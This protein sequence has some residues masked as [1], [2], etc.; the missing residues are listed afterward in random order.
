MKKNKGFNL[1][2]KAKKNILGGTMMLSKKPELWLPKF[3]PTYFKKANKISVW[4]L[5][6]K[7]YIDMICAVGQNT[8]GYSNKRIDD[9]V[10]RSIKNNNMTTLNCP[11]EVE[12]SEILL[13]MNP[14]AD[15][16]KFARTGGEANSI[17]IRIA[18]AASKK[19][20]I[21]IC[22]Y[23]GWHDWYLAVNLTKKDGLKKHLLGGLK[24]TGVPK[25]LKNT[26]YPFEYGRI[27]QLKEIIKKKNIGIIKI[28]VARSALPDKKFIKGVSQLA[29]RNKI[30]LIFDECTSGFRRNFGGLYL[31]TGVKPDIVI[32]GKAIGN[33]YA[34]TAVVGNKK[35]MTAASSCFI[36][37][38]F[39]TE[40][41]GYVAAINTLKEMQRI[42]SWKILIK[43][44]K[45][46]INGLKK[47]GKKYNLN[48]KVEGIESIINFNFLSKYNIYYKTYITQEMLKKGYLASNITYVTIHHNKA[49]VDRY[50]KQMELIFKKIEN[51]ERDK[52]VKKYLN[53]PVCATSFGRLTN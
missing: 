49:T 12:L 52:N 29:K 53:G 27:D 25:F 20:N 13:K 43:N 5:N 41:I 31:N 15:K 36:S 11:E 38:T 26:I 7:K 51:F 37:S 17:A 33:G 14:W 16:V 45:H 9:I 35:V 3:W 6:N 24:T 40:K 30:I 48:L 32:Y 22:G 1:Y 42:K 44:G 23:H 34:L 46:I 21:A 10:I 39:W 47:L 18:R 50:L 4:D 28:E 8:L 19:D 2:L